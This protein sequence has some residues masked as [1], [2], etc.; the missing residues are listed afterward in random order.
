MYLYVDMVWCEMAQNPSTLSYEV[1]TF[2][3]PRS[4]FTYDPSKSFVNDYNV[5][6]LGFKYYDY[7]ICHQ[8][9]I[10]Y[11]TVPV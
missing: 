6:A 7:N 2:Y 11:I 10:L 1:T 9:V 3:T 5:R 8:C 4:S